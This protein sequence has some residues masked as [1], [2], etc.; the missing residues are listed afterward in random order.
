MTL[1]L[2]TCSLIISSQG[3][4]RHQRW[5]EFTGQVGVVWLLLL[6]NVQNKQK[7]HEN[8]WLI[9]HISKTFCTVLWSL[10]YS[11]FS[12]QTECFIMSDTLTLPSHFCFFFFLCVEF[13][14]NFPPEKL[15]CKNKIKQQTLDRMIN[16]GLWISVYFW[17]SINKRWGFEKQQNVLWNVFK[18]LF[19]Q[20]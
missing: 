18:T 19:L 4:L 11:S 2:Q 5:A 15:H 13:V 6:N 9:Q 20:D 7:E 14:F 10:F 8:N 17:N 16:V 12:G 1:V 3:R